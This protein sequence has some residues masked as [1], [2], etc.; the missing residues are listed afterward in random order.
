MAENIN[1]GLV[2]RS[3]G[4]PRQCYLMDKAIRKSPP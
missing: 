2:L 4:H 1:L 3:D